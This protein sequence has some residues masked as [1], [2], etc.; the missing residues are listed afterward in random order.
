M[1]ARVRALPDIAGLSAGEFGTTAT[2]G[3]GGRVEGVAVRPEGVE[4]GVVVRYGRPIPDIAA[5]V[6]A[7][8]LAARGGVP[9]SGDGV[10]VWVA[11][12]DLAEAGTR[13]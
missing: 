12:I 8:V 4:V 1:A 7:A 13:R 3:P 9:D 10:R 2:P 5:D 6:R 11:D